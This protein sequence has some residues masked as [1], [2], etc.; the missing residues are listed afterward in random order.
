MSDDAGTALVILLVVAC[1]ICLRVALHFIDRERIFRAACRKG[2][3][4]IEVKWAP[5]ARGFFFEKGERHYRVTYR[6]SH[7]GRRTSICKTSLL[8]GIYWRD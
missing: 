6:D 2:W 7:G 3:R 5:F 8:T 1:V 4:D